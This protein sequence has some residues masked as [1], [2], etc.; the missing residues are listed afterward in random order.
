MK[1]LLKKYIIIITVFT[2]IILCYFFYLIGNSVTKSEREYYIYRWLL[3]SYADF[4]FKKLE[5]N[6]FDLIDIDKSSNEYFS[7]PIDRNN[8]QYSERVKGEYEF[9]FD[10]YNR[11]KV[12]VNTQSKSIVVIMIAKNNSFKEKKLSLGYGI[13]YNGNWIYFKRFKID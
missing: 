8:I 4:I 5:K 11:P 7:S 2:I 13:I 9:Y 1:I 10:I 3:A 6:N 12:Y